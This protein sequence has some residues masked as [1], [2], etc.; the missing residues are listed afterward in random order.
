MHGDVCLQEHYFSER[1]LQCHQGSAV[2]KETS[3]IR[4]PL[5]GSIQGRQSFARQ[6]CLQAQSLQL[7]P[8]LDNSMVCT[9]RALSMGFCRQ[10]LWNGLLFPPPGN[11][12]DP[13]IKPMSPVS[14]ALQA[15]FF[16][17]H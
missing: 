7:C 2:M 4:G 16:F 15:D 12:P 17:Y 6:D 9:C 13:G 11:L 10:E 8:T 14:P 1:L 5:S 3:S